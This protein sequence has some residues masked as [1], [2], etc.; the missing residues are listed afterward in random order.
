MTVAVDVLLKPMSTQ[1]PLGFSSCFFNKLKA[2]I[3]KNWED[4]D[5]KLTSD[6][7]CQL[8]N[9]DSQHR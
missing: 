9:I 7:D 2:K 3:S 6:V 1:K 4:D 8:T 5:Q